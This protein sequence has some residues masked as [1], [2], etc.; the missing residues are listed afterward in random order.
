[1]KLCPICATSYP[2]EHRTCPTHGTILVETQELPAG[3]MIRDCYRIVR[4]LGKGGMG[5]VYLAEHTL[6]GEPRALKFLSADLA[7]NPSF[8]QRFLQ[9]ARAAN[10]LRHPNVAQTM[11]LGQTEDGSFYISM[12]FVDG[13]SLRSA[14]NQSPGGLA[15]ERAFNIVHGV[16]AGLGAA[17]AKRMVHRD[18]KPEN[19]L[20]ASTPEGEV[21]KVV[22]FG[23]VAMS[24]GAGRLTQTGSVLLTCEYAAPEQWRGTVPSSE[25]DGRTDLYAV[26]C[27]FFEM[28]TGRL[29]FK[30]D[31]YEGWFELH[32]RTN[33]PP[34]SSIR[35]ELGDFPGL[36]ALVLKLL[37]KDRENRPANVAE[38]LADLNRV[39]GGSASYSGSTIP[40]FSGPIAGAVSEP[41]PGQDQTQRLKTLVEAPSMAGGFG[42]PAAPAGTTNPSVSASNSGAGLAQ[43]LASSWADG[44][45]SVPAVGTTYGPVSG[46]GPGQVQGQ[47][48]GSVPAPPAVQGG[49][50]AEGEPAIQPPTVGPAF[51]ANVPTAG[52]QG[53]QFVPVQVPGQMPGQV[54]ARPPAKLANSNTGLIL[55]ILL[56]L[57]VLIGIAGFGAVMYMRNKASQGQASNQS[58][59]PGTT[60]TQAQTQPQTPPPV[61]AEPNA[62]TGT[63]AGSSG[64][65]GFD[66]NQTMPGTAPAPVTTPAA[67][68]RVPAPKKTPEANGGGATAQ[69]ADDLYTSKQYAQAQP[70]LQQACNK[71]HAESCNYLGVMYQFKLG[72]DQDYSQAVTLYNKA[73]NGGNMLGCNNLAFLYQHKLGVDEDFGRALALYQKACN[74]GEP[75]ACNSLGVMYQKSQGVDS[76]PV[77]AAAL[78]LKACD[79]GNANGCSDLGY[80]YTKGTGVSVDLA[81]AKL[82]L[83]KGCTMGNKFGCDQLKLLN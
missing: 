61:P 11:E 32:V 71:G 76:D 29:P 24:D 31:S 64:S 82:Y 25:L 65:S 52:S 27:M 49:W 83:G 58:Q 6:M 74:G 70:L 75:S 16:A 62:A 81:K 37:E 42:T 50:P 56:G 35:P 57:V 8:V 39:I 59:S 68:P 79:G 48:S 22:D 72:V 36:D 12:E 10:K 26:G 34:P 44:A 18:V 67:P 14:L 43:G 17:H 7:S 51:P 47:V 5:T 13:P 1:M 77:R 19:I 2:A 41:V 55:F 80:L 63:D 66:P 3:S 15:T 23:I 20:L 60:P 21:A 40:A 28:L 45:G 69:Q 4:M 78:Y 73:C 54:L 53:G 38:F 46:Q 33:P 30:S 9:E